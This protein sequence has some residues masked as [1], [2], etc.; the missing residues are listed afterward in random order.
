[1]ARSHERA[2]C[3]TSFRDDREQSR[4][5]GPIHGRDAWSGCVRMEALHDAFDG[6]SS[7][8]R[9]LLERTAGTADAD[10][11]LLRVMRQSY[12]R[13]AQR[14]VRRRVSGLI[15]RTASSIRSTSSR[16]LSGS[17]RC[18]RAGRKAAAQFGAGEKRFASASCSRSSS[19][20]LMLRPIRPRSVP[21]PAGPKGLARLSAQKDPPE[22]RTG[23]QTTLSARRGHEA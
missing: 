21:W 9:P 23:S 4:D 1:M 20:R 7:K 17:S 11:D 3:S 22:G 15:V 16:R 12:A 6:R 2:R 19:A 8:P 13:R 14:L 5:Q 10:R 18:R